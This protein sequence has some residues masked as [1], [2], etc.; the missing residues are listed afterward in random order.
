MHS[1]SVLAMLKNESSIIKDWIEHYL[2]EGVDHFYLIDNGTTDDTYKILSRYENYITLIKD[3]RRMPTGTQTFLMNA[4]YLHNIR[5]ETEWV[6]ICD[7]DEYIYS[8]KEYPQIR[9]FLKTI[10]QNIDK[11]WIPWKCFGSNG[12]ITQ[13]DKVIK[14][15]T[16]RQAGISIKMEHGKVICRAK[17]LIKILSGG[18][19]ADLSRHNS[20]YLCNMQL[21]STIKHADDII[22]EDQKLHLNHYMLMSEEYYKNNKCVRG[23]GETGH[24]TDKF[25]MPAFYNMDSSFNEIQDTE[26]ARKKYSPHKKKTNRL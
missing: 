15:F 3:V 19:M 20:Y 2:A 11:I 16:K 1:I 8:R 22:L 5:N 17:N 24:T 9:D 21:L 13:P 23:G 18:N 10:P 4:I 26:L 7:V 12:H 25:T 6:I 14:S